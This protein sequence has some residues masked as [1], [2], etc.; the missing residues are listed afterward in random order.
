MKRSALQPDFRK[1]HEP[2]ITPILPATAL[3][4]LATNKIIETR[5][6]A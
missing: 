1:S 4:R 5:P 2:F 6:G 3:S